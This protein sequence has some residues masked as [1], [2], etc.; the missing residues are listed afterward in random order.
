M[1]N[2][3]V[4]LDTK[5]LALEAQSIET[6]QVSSRFAEHLQHWRCHR[7]DANVQWWLLDCARTSTNTLSQAVL[8]ELDELVTNVERTEKHQ[9]R[10]VVIRSAKTNGFIAGA[11]IGEFRGI[12]DPKAVADPLRKGA[13][14]LER[15]AKLH[16]PT[17][18]VIHGFCL[19]AG[20]ELAL[21]C[22]YRL[23]RSNSKLGFP[24]VLLGLHPGLG[25]TVRLTRQIRPT[26]ALNLMLTGKSITANKAK[27]LGMVDVV[28]EERHFASAIDQAIAGN[29][30]RRGRDKMTR[31]MQL[32]PVAR[33]IAYFAEKQ[34]RRKANEQQYPAPFAL[35][36]LWRKHSA[37]PRAMAAAERDSFANLLT[38]ETAQNLVRVFFLREGMK[39][40]GKGNAGIRHVHVIGAGTMGG[41]IATWCAIYGLQVTL[42]D[43]APRLIAPA[44]KKAHQLVVEKLRG[45]PER[46][47]ALDRLIPDVRGYG[48]RSA[49]LIIEAV[50][51]KVE[52]KVKILQEVE[53][54]AKRSAVI[55]TNTS[56]IM[57]ESLRGSLQDPSRF[58]GIHFFN[59]VAK[60]QLVEVV[61]HDQV[62]AS[63]VQRAL[64]FVHQL[65]RLPVAVKSAP[66]FLVNRVLTPYLL[67]A[68]ALIDEGH[69][70]E[71]IDQAGKDFG[72]PMGPVEL[73][74]LIGLDICLHVAETLHRGLDQELYPIP[75]WLHERI[76]NG[77]Y[78][79]KSGQGLYRYKK[80]KI[81]KEK[82]EQGDN[83]ALQQ[84][85]ILPMLNTC[86]HCL[87]E[88]I[89][90]DPDH[91]DGAII[92]ATGFA[93]FT[94]G[95][96]RY[97]ERLGVEAIVQQLTALQREH[98]DRFKPAAGW[99]TH[100]IQSNET[101][102]DSDQE[103]RIA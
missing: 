63:T 99:H 58:I 28:C 33:T 36:D 78:G 27:Q 60:M 47:A 52:L 85:L 11:E 40:A 21:A 1:V 56:S 34:T 90:E 98:G 37:Q 12:N 49:D 44:I 62:S 45:A 8:T 95:P 100:F 18:A 97:S 41:D 83:T 13:K 16:A 20:L 39:N 87:D 51:E 84:R 91:L 66:G 2:T 25:G 69:S 93:P 17:V 77:E 9:V 79:K 7:N 86:V 75:Q 42:E 101:T 102:S 81:Q 38:T 6:G 5:S 29:L 89:V 48:R 80:G 94:G 57:L 82:F 4:N 3:E 67:E 103:S 24:E 71:A 46:Q 55:A 23:A 72:M 92:F 61:T 14:L 30:A 50:P 74:D 22:K 96:L 65:D 15:L 26:K 54:T 35:I 70:K 64:S 32:P 88:G 31:F 19:G 73:A 59:P 76:D 53:A 43:R 10:G 68:L